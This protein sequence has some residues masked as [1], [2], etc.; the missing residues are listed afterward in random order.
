MAGAT[1]VLHARRKNQAAEGNQDVVGEIGQQ[2]TPFGF[3]LD[4]A[5]RPQQPCLVT[6]EAADAGTTDQVG[7][8]QSHGRRRQGAEDAASGHEE[9]RHWVGRDLG[10]R[11]NQS[12][13]GRLAGRE[14]KDGAIAVGLTPGNQTQ[15]VET[16]HKSMPVC[17]VVDQASTPST[18][19]SD[20]SDGANDASAREACDETTAKWPSPTGSDRARRPP[21]RPTSTTS[22]ERSSTYARE[23]MERATPSRLSLSTARSPS[24]ICCRAEPAGWPASVSGANRTWDPELWPSAEWTIVEEGACGPGTAPNAGNAGSATAVADG[25]SGLWASAISATTALTGDV[26][27]SSASP[28]GS[29]VS[30]SSSSPLVSSKGVTMA[31]I[32]VWT[33]PLSGIPGATGNAVS[34]AVVVDRTSPL[35]A[36]AISKAAAPPA[37]TTVNS[38]RSPAA[39]ATRAARSGRWRFSSPPGA[40]S[41]PRRTALVVG[42]SIRRLSSIGSSSSALPTATSQPAR[43]A[44]SS[45]RRR[46][47]RDPASTAIRRCGV[48][49]AMSR[50]H[51]AT[52]ARVSTSSATPSAAAI[53]STRARSVWR[54][55]FSRPASRTSTSTLQGA[56]VW[57]MRRHRPPTCPSRAADVVAEPWSIAKN[58]RG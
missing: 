2:A 48:V 8:G 29:A 16:I 49:R 53:S 4:D 38:G 55:W 5:Q 17:V 50:G 51:V 9:P 23:A 56:E 45:R 20:G 58:A 1:T 37:S 54:I 41:A 32:F 22:M 21:C 12:S 27:G 14:P 10:R 35:D 25:A 13:E 7:Q 43:R 19:S 3:V 44:H 34:G 18:T 28:S 42:D 39:A 57:A 11:L 33:G 6:G 36:K 26:A 46:C 52:K 15:I 47:R 31:A 30:V 24:R 40:W